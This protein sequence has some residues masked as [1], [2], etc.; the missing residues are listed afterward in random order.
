MNLLSK[1]MNKIGAI[2]INGTSFVR[3]FTTGTA[4]LDP[5]SILATTKGSVTFTLMGAQVGDVIIMQPPA[6]LEAGLLHI[7]AAVTSANTVSVYLFN[8]TGSPVDGA[9]L[10][11]VYLWIKLVA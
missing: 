2:S 1:A 6:T 8:D 9:S 11:W 4:T 10:A 5:A 3:G 7:G